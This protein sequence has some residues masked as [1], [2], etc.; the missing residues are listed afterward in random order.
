MKLPIF[1]VTPLPVV[2]QVTP[3]QRSSTCSACSLH[4]STPAGERCIPADGDIG[5]ILVVGSSPTEFERRLGR[6]MASPA[7]L[8]LRKVFEERYPDRKVVYTNAIGCKLRRDDDDAEEAIAA[9]RPHVAQDLLEA[10]PRVIILLGSIAGESVLGRGFQPLSVRK[11]YGWFFRDGQARPVFLL[12]NPAAIL[13]NRL[14]TQAFLDDLQAALSAD[15]SPELLQSEYTVVQDEQAAY[16][17]AERLSRAPFVATDVETSGMMHEDDFR[18][19]CVAVSSGD[20]TY[21]WSRKGIEDPG[22]REHLLF[23]LSTLDHTSWNG[24][25]DWAAFACDP[26]FAGRDAYGRP[27][28]PMRLMSDARIK[29]KL[30]EADAK[31]D[32]ATAA[33]LIGMGGHKEEAHTLVDTISTEIHKYHLATKLT[34][35]GKV[36]KPP[37]LSYFEPAN[38]PWEAWSKYLDDGFE[39]VKFAYRFM[40]LDILHRY[41][42]RDALTTWHLEAWANDQIIQDDGLATIWDEVSQKSMWAYCAMRLNGLP[43]DAGSLRLFQQFLETEMQKVKASID[44]YCK[45]LNPLS[46]KQVGAYLQ[47]VGIVPH[48]KTDSGAPSYS[49]ESLEEYKDKHPMVDLILHY[50]E[51][52]KQLGTYAI[53]FSH[54]IR[55]DGRVHP[56]ILSDGTETGRPSASEPNCFTGDTEIL[57]QNRGW[58]RMDG[59][60]MGDIVA[61]AIPKN[62]WAAIEWAQPTG[63]VQKDFHGELVHLHNGHIDLL[64]TPDH[65]CPTRNRKDRIFREYT[66]LTYP[67][68]AH[69]LNAGSLVSPGIE[70][71]RNWITLLC[72]TQADGHF[73]GSGVAFCFRKKRKYDRLVAALTSLGAT[74]SHR[75]PT[76]SEKTYRVYIKH[77]PYQAQLYTLLG[78]DKVFGP[79]LLAWDHASLRALTE[80]V[81]FWDGDAAKGNYYASTD[82]RNMDYVQA[83]YSLVGK[84]AFLGSYP[85]SY[86]KGKTIH[87]M[88]A[89]NV[90]Y[91]MTTN[92]KRE[93][94]HHDGKVYCVSVPSSY[95]LVRRNGKTMITGN[96]LNVSK[97]RTERKKQ[98]ADMLRASFICPPGWSFI[99]VDSGQIEIRG[100]AH[101]SGDQAMHEMLTSGTDFHMASAKRF[102]SAQGKDP[103]AVTDLDRE[104][105]KTCIAEGELVL[106]HRGLVPIENVGGCD[107]VWDGVEWVPHDGL[108]PMGRRRVITYDGLTATPD[109]QVYLDDG[110]RCALSEVVASGRRLAISGAGN[111]PIR[112]AFSHQENDSEGSSAAAPCG[113]AEV[114]DI[115]NAG[116]RH[117]FTVSG[118]LVSNCNF[119]AVYEIPCQLGFMLSSRIGVE[120]KVGQQIADAMFQSYTGLR[121]WMDAKYAEAWKTGIARTQWKGKPAR[122]R[123]LWGMGKNPPTLK[124]LEAA[125][126]ADRGRGSAKSLYDLN[127]ARSTYNGPNQGSSVDVI[128]SHLWEVQ[129]WLDANTRGGQLTLQVYDS[130]MVMVR[131]E[132]VDKTLEFLLNVMVEPLFGSTPLT[133]DAKVGK[134][135]G[136]MKKIKLTK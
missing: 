64:V 12:Q 28:S 72:A 56:S 116:P 106:T 67:K 17:A 92:V 25:Y 33:E 74:F 26:L 136:S 10:D 30:L 42:A 52:Q 75:E 77:S 129:Q 114:Y 79:W 128:A 9:C 71:D 34:P 130:I 95:I 118:R 107:L 35:S 62:G 23:V 124:E 101:L 47:S 38:S 16:E 58:V 54:Y 57:T 122:K 7:G 73:N 127:A 44:G 83:A 88:G 48:R 22:A 8:W 89:K 97:G 102:A 29:R 11:G 103:E 133:A 51:L 81:P 126:V 132:D 109:H 78:K 63:I 123:P 32:L 111:L 99:E 135:W 108:L 68:D 65:R 59:V 131:D 37:Q 4:A 96:C 41:C 84:R 40:P 53:G 87:V 39:P 117:R 61:Q 6:P 100:A 98:L 55:K 110:T 104:F 120:K 93:R 27:T 1:P 31:A 66:A 45:G 3:C 50:R 15:P 105:A 21:V 69:Q 94:I 70:V 5:D 125:L 113:W 13:G 24:Q 2:Q 134:T 76:L 36:R 85:Y 119:A 60:G 82:R 91:S 86:D 14:L 43:L 20:R 18:I 80:E 49:D 121:V 115:A 112:N 19:E 46:P 90:D